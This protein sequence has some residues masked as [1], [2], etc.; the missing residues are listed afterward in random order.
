MLFINVPFEEITSSFIEQVGDESTVKYM[1]FRH[2]KIRRIHKSFEFLPG[3]EEIWLGGNPFYC[4]CDMTWMIPWLNSF[5]NKSNKPLVQD[6]AEIKCSN[7]KFK[8]LA[9][10]LLT[11]VLLGCYPSKWTT[12]QK[13]GVGVAAVMV[14]IIF[15]LAV[16]AVKYSSFIKFI[17]FYKFKLDTIPKDDKN[18]NLDNREYDGFL[19]YW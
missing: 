1:D 4:D 15:S 6:V 11:D 13:A 16:V 12:G 7:G 9:V 8:G 14:S 18:E 2:S 17:L 3:L 10:H 19:C 5:N